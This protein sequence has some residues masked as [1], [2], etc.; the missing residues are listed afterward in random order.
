MLGDPIGVFSV[1][2]YPFHLL[3]HSRQA[4]QNTLSAKA[5]S[6]PG[7]ASPELSHGMAEYFV[8]CSCGFPLHMLGI[9]YTLAKC[10]NVRN[11]SLTWGQK[12]PVPKGQRPVSGVSASSF[13][14]DDPPPSLC[15]PS[16]ASLHSAL[17]TPNKTATHGSLRPPKEGII[18]VCAGRH[19]SS[20]PSHAINK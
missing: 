15:C 9:C 11:T 12:S 7:R 10:L 5:L 3:T 16:S 20:I 6:E 8:Q 2:R 18:S 13:P 4:R 1:T 14:A 17:G 19:H